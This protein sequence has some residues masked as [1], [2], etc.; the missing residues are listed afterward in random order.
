MHFPSGGLNNVKAALSFPVIN[1]A[2][3]V[4]SEMFVFGIPIEVLAVIFA[5]LFVAFAASALM[6]WRRD[7]AEQLRIEREKLTL[8]RNRL[9]E[10]TSQAVVKIGDEKGGGYRSGGYIVI[11]MSERERRFFHDLLNGFED[12][13]KLKGYEIAFSIDAASDGRIGFKFTMR[14]DDQQVA[15]EQVKRDF[16]EYLQEVVNGPIEGL[17]RLP[18]VTSVEEHNTVVLL[19]KNRLSFLHHSYQAAKFT[20]RH[21]EKLLSDLHAHHL[22]GPAQV[23]VHTGGNMESKSYTATHAS[24]VVQG[25]GNTFED[26]SINI[27][28]GQSFNQKQER[29]AAI[30]DVVERHKEA[31]AQNQ[32]AQKARRALENVRDEIT[33]SQEPDKS[34]VH[35]WLE[36]AKNSMATAALGLEATEAAKKLFELFGLS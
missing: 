6:M 22:L 29:I 17:D 13:A 3:L 12:Y 15:A 31:D 10:E 19:L 24:R 27:D 28:I 36:V 30:N 1:D 23:V 32:P 9:G 35:K 14:A 21:Y 26:S 25:D 8:E 5:I 4:S 11:E 16:K 2:I 34:T 33:D 18:I 20:A 7:R